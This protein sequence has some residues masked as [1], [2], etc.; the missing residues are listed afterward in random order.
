MSPK[1]EVSPSYPGASQK[2][3]RALNSPSSNHEAILTT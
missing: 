2:N 3:S 1:S